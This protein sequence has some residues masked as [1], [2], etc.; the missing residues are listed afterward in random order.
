MGVEWRDCDVV[1]ELLGIK[2]FLNEFV[3]YAKLSEY[4][5]NRQAENGLRTISVSPWPFPLTGS[6]NLLETFSIRFFLWETTNCSLQ[7]YICSFTLPGF[8]ILARHSFFSAA[9]LLGVIHLFEFKNPTS[10]SQTDKEN[11]FVPLNMRLYNFKWEKN[12]P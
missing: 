10:T 4:I 2:T 7:L 6:L 5:K 12:L 3:A 9:M 11:Y 1:A 8:Q